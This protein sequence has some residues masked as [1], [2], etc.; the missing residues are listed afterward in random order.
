MDVLDKIPQLSQPDANHVVYGGLAGLVLAAIAKAT[1]M[2]LQEAVVA[3]LAVVFIITLAKKA[4]D[5]RFEA[6]SLRVCAWKLGIT[7]LWPASA[8][9]IARLARLC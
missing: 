3:A 1:G 2:S 8:V 7:L 5:Y 6:E 4:Y 9:I